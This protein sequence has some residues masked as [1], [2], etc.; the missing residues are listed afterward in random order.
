MSLESK[1]CTEQ[2]REHDSA[3]LKQTCRAIV[4]ALATT[5]FTM[6]S[7]PL[8][9]AIKEVAST[10]SSSLF[11]SV[12]PQPELTERG[13]TVRKDGRSQQSSVDVD[14]PT[15]QQLVHYVDTTQVDSDHLP[16]GAVP[17]AS[18][19]RPR[20]ASSDS[21][22]GS[23]AADDRDF[24]SLQQADIAGLY[25]I[26]ALVQAIR[27]GIVSRGE[28]AL[29]VFRGMRNIFTYELLDSDQLQ[30][31][32]KRYFGDVLANVLER[33]YPDR[34]DTPVVSEGIIYANCTRENTNY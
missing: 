7:D 31:R 34:G 13:M 28:M 12:S 33:I 3:G 24:N 6:R 17:P 9:S 4:T 2:R 8:A 23:P 1:S 19:R 32:L 5:D 21:P 25:N 15:L 30:R 29:L 22:N 26:P 10:T 14:D 11:V 16:P 20:P 27:D 18:L